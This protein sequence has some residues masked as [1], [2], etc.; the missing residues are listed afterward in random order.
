MVE[1]AKL[2]APFAR[3]TA[4]TDLRLHRVIGEV[5]ESDGLEHVRALPVALVRAHRLVVGRDVHELDAREALLEVEVDLVR[6]RGRADEADAL[7]RQAGG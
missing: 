1:Y 7:Q 6:Q 2:V 3:Q 4:G 5:A